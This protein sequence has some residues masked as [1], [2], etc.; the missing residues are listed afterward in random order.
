[1]PLNI[2]ILFLFF[3]QITPVLSDAR[4]GFILKIPAGNGRAESVTFSF[5]PDQH[6]TPNNSKSD[7]CVSFLSCHVR[8]LCWVNA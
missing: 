7:S 8:I 3:R 2:S 1:M 5:F 4:Q 6:E